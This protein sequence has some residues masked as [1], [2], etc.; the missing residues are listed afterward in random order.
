[1]LMESLNPSGRVQRY[2][3]IV[4]TIPMERLRWLY[5]VR[6]HVLATGVIFLTDEANRTS[7]VEMLL[8]SLVLLAI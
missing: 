3:R 4:K 8:W 6:D 7:T 2:F 5:D 1:M